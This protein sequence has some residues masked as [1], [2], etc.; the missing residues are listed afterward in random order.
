MDVAAYLDRIGYSGTV[1]ATLDVL[2][3]IHARHPEAIAF[4]NFDAFCGVTAQLDVES[5]EQKLVRGGRGGWCFE[6]N[7]L[8][9][10]VLRACGFGVRELAARVLWNAPEGALRPRSHMVLRVDVEAQRYLVDVG[11]GGQTLTGPLQFEVDLEQATPHE[12]F[13]LVES[14]EEFILETEV[15]GLWRPLY[16]FDL[17]PQTLPDY[18]VTN[19]YLSTHPSSHFRSNLVAARAVPGRRYALF[20][21]QFAV[22]HTGGDTERRQLASVDELRAVLE[23]TFLLRLPDTPELER[24]LRRVLLA[25]DS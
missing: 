17:Q 1:T 15:Q 23:E 7:L 10:H 11:F 14:G 21:D 20:N 18:E 12:R 25:R 19:W 8:L 6:Q 13:R 16:R 2:R 24:N 4:E 9:A 22:H 3:E 5:L